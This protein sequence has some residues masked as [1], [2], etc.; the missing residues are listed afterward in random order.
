MQLS[1]KRAFDTSVG[2]EEEK[3][4]QGK[5]F[6]NYYEC[7]LYA[8]ILGMRQEYHRLVTFLIPPPALLA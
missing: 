2:T 6:A 7:F 5:I 4:A 1:R 3:Y 8:T